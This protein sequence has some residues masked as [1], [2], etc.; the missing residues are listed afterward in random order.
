MSLSD[1]TMIK[2]YPLFEKEIEAL[3]KKEKSLVLSVRNNITMLPKSFFVGLTVKKS[4]KLS[5]LKNRLE[6]VKNR[7][8]IKAKRTDFAPHITL[9]YPAKVNRLKTMKSPVKNLKFDRITIVKKEGRKYRIHKHIRF[10]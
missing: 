4:K 10:G 7:H 1:G 5:A 8:S 3:C 6:A 9:A 2:D